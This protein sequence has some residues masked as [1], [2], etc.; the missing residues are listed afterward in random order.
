MCYNVI[1]FDIKFIRENPEKVQ[2]NAR[3]KGYKNLDVQKLLALDN[4]FR[5]KL[6]EV[7]ELREKKNENSRKI[8]TV[9]GKP[10]PEILASGR[11]IKDVLALSEK[12]LT[13]REKTFLDELK[14]WPNMARDDVPVGLSED[15]NV[16]AKTVGTIPKF[17]FAPKNH[18]EIAEAK[19]WLDSE[20]AVKVAGSRFLY[21]KGDLARLEFALWQFIINTLTDPEKIREIRK[22]VDPEF[23]DQVSDKIFTFTLPPAMAKTEVFEATGRLNKTEQT[24][25]LE[26]EDL[27]LNASAEH[28]LSPMFLGEI[29]DEHDLPL[30]FLGYTTAFRR[31]AGTY[32]K[33]MVGM[34]RLHQFNKMEMEIFATKEQSW[35]EHLFTIAVE[36]YI[37]QKL[38]IPYRVLRKCTF[39]IGRPN[40]SG[41]DIEAWMPGQMG[42][43]GAYRETHTADFIGDFQTRAMKTRVRR[44]DGSVELANTDDA[45]ASSERPLIALIEN[46]QTETGDVVVPEV[47]RPFMG[48]KTQI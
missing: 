1:M 4:D 12:E 2:E 17:D 16:V 14:L 5:E 9:G 38:A 10:T 32:G 46:F 7:E 19:G 26:D 27:W 18:A 11:K 34:M 33:D 23:R 42:G 29:L 30:R 48:G 47:L 36:E 41:V 28:T 44:T 25:K 15:E 35:P 3:N 39:D 40:A 24:Y 22:M 43:A 8:K 45:T 20:R 6:A 21:I 13:D 37:M 31:E